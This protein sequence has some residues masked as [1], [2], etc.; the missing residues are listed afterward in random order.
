MTLAKGL[1]QSKSSQI[2]IAFSIRH[3]EKRLPPAAR[4]MCRKGDVMYLMFFLLSF[5]LLISLFSL[6]N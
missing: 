1:L 4:G 5:F 3:V 2:S 6:V